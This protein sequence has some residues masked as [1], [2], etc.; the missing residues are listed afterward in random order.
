MKS[1]HISDII[2]DYLDDLLDP[3]QHHEAEEHLRSCQSCSAE[4]EETRELLKAFKEEKSAIPSTRLKNRFYQMLE[5]E[6]QNSSDFIHIDRKNSWVPGLLKIAAG[7]ALL[8]GAFTLGKFQEQKQSN[9]AI[10]AL[11][12]ESL[13]IKETAMLSLMEN[14][15]ASRRIQGVNYIEEFAE[16]DEAIIV[17]LADRMLH[18]DNKNVR[19][20]AVEA[21]GNFTSSETVKT[22]FISALETENDPSIQITIIHTLVAIQEK[23]AIPPMQKLLQQQETQPFVKQQI[24]SLI[25]NII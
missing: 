20:S 15:S 24:K 11:E 4:L 3:V 17:A 13:E 22:A 10:A 2:A 8:A 1:N 16:P 14:Q 12:N 9:L 21:L 25:P 5:E 18:D 7:I 23:K 19:L 6:K